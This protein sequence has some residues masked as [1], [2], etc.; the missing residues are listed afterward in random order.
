M[1][2]LYTTANDSQARF[3]KQ[4]GDPSHGG[5]VLVRAWP[6]IDPT[7]ADGLLTTKRAETTVSDPKADEQQY[8]GTFVKSRLHPEAD[9][10]GAVTIYETLTK[11]TSVAADTTLFGLTPERE[12]VR[13]VIHPYDSA[14]YDPSVDC[15]EEDVVTFKYK[16]LN[17]ASYTYLDSIADSTYETNLRPDTSWGFD[18]VKIVEDGDD[19]TMRLEVAFRK[20]VMD[21]TIGTQTVRALVDRAETEKRMYQQGTETVIPIAGDTGVG[22][23][24]VSS[25]TRREDGSFDKVKSVSSALPHSTDTHMSASVSGRRDSSYASY[26]DTTGPADVP[27]AVKRRRVVLENSKNPDG[28]YTLKTAIS[29]SVA[30]S[31]ASASRAGAAGYLD[32][33][34]VYTN[35]DSLPTPGQS[36]QGVTISISGERL[37]A[38]STVDYSKTV[39]VAQA[40]DTSGS[41]G[42]VGYTDSTYVYKNQSALPTDV[43]GKGTTI[44]VRP[45]LNDDDTVD[46]VKSVRVA[47]AMD[48]GPVVDGTVA[49]K[50]SAYVYRNQS[51]VTSNQGGQGTTISV[52]PLGLNQDGTIDYTKSVRVAAAIDTS[53]TDGTVG[54]GDS[55]YVYRNQAS[56]TA[57]AGGKGVTISV[58]PRLN[59]DDTV[60]YVKNIRTVVAMDTG[61]A[62][63]GVQG[64]T[65]SVYVYRHQSSLPELGKADTGREYALGGVNLADDGTVSYV[66]RVRDYDTMT[67]ELEYATRY[68]T[69]YIKSVR[70]GDSSDA[71]TDAAA[72]TDTT[73]NHL[74]I[75][76]ADMGKVDYTVTKAPYGSQGSGARTWDSHFASYSVWKNG[77]EYT[78]KRVVKYYAA[79]SGASA[80]AFVNASN[81]EGFGMYPSGPVWKAIKVTDTAA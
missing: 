34:Y 79:S 5:F 51:S 27:A 14:A 52:R 64:F 46:Y 38:D 18:G 4:D 65:D 20:E 22:K 80:A 75:H 10:E 28:T 76:R 57:G 8:S 63:D 1:G 9:A 25:V 31:T 72:L 55:I 66:K 29:K 11:V 30:Q 44:S 47:N 17:P 61:P 81:A 43:G 68:G 23:T 7:E 56:V 59:D 32:S 21:P 37:N 45:R 24:V 69:A 15:K 2:D 78:R 70:H 6:K 67:I 19:N 54:F 26:N 39:R 77:V 16:Y 62:T 35:Q 3:F 71:A 50:D 13:R 40:L 33:T 58:R 12:N 36:G 41:D 74:S 60:D 42:T 53:T 49:Y 48:S 73:S